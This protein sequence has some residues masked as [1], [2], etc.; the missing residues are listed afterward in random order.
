MFG[1]PG[2]LYVYFVYGM[3]FC[4]NVTCLADGEAGAV[5]L[6]AG[7][8]T[9]DLAV[10]LRAGARPRG[11][12]ASWRAARPGWRRCSGS[13]RAHNGVDVTD[14]RSPVRVLA[15]PPVGPGTGADGP[16][17]RRGRRARAALAVLARRLARG[18]HLPPRPGRAGEVAGGSVP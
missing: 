11:A 12:T 13:D 18:Q 2:H 17:G 7:E 3:H 9:S 15:G 1:P 16:A 4:A 8:V 6:R 5:L 14:P 10:G